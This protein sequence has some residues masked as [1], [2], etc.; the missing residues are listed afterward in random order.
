MPSAYVIKI[1]KE[2]GIS[3]QAAEAKWDAAKAVV[4][5]KYP[6]I[7]PTESNYNFYALVVTVFKRMMHLNEDASTAINTTSKIGNIKKRKKAKNIKEY[8]HIHD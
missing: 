7:K 5:S 6:N 1:A 3:I 2:K 8:L 4:K